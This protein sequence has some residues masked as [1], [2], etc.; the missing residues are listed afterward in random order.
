MSNSSRRQLLKA[1]TSSSGAI[2]VGKSLPEEWTKPIIDSVVLPVHARTSAT[3]P[4]NPDTPCTQCGEQML[5][6][7]IGGPQ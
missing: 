1:L 3:D 7:G 4:D 6:D 2:V 5:A